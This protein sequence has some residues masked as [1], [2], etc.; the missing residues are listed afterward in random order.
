MH[1]PLKTQALSL[2]EEYKGSLDFLLSTSGTHIADAQEVKEAYGAKAN[3]K[4]IEY[5]YETL[6]EK[7]RQESIFCFI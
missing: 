2:K 7:K 3:L 6:G 5:E 4:G 1:S